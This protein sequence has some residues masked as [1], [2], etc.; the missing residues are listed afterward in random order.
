MKLRA[1]VAAVVSLSLTAACGARARTDDA[2]VVAPTATA[3]APSPPPA[4]VQSASLPRDIEWL[5]AGNVRVPNPGWA[6]RNEGDV[7]VLVAPGEKGGLVFTHFRSA[8]EARDIV[9]DFSEKLGMK[10]LTWGP[11]A[12]VFFGPDRFPALFAEG[13]GLDAKGVPGKMFY[14]LIETG[15]THNVFVMGGADEDAPAVY[16]EALSIVRGIRKNETAPRRTP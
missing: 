11:V 7:G 9:R 10:D 12:K 14:A 2:P 4:S 1:R 13:R 3:S 6:P 15:E 8:D 5:D 16:D